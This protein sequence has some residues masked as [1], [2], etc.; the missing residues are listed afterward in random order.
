MKTIITVVFTFFTTGLIAQNLPK[1]DSA[2]INNQLETNRYEN[3]AIYYYLVNN[4]KSNTDKFEIE[5]YEWDSTSICSFRQNFEYG[6]KYTVW[7]CKEAGGI[8]E[9]IEFPQTDK[10]E[11]K[12]W[13][14]QMYLITKSENDDNIWKEG[15]TKFEPRE[16]TP[17]CYYEIN[18]QDNKTI[19]EL[20][21]G[22]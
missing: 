22:C 7:Q 6:I 4:F 3:A 19:V 1:P 13:V 17:G 9:T 10:E 5:Y 8:T 20:Y 16:I 18:K 21:C 11:I 12:Q 2:K 15:D 14:E